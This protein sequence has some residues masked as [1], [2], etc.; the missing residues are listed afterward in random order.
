MIEECACIIIGYATEHDVVRQDHQAHSRWLGRPHRGD[1][2]CFII[3]APDT[4]L[5]VTA[6]KD[7]EAIIAVVF[8][9]CNMLMSDHIYSVFDSRSAILCFV[10]ALF[11]FSVFVLCFHLCCLLK[12]HYNEFN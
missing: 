11:V 3:I 8:L 7:K 1:S 12:P 2:D 10:P 5:I 6:F 9:L 4:I